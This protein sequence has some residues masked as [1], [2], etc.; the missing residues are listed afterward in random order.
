LSGLSPEFEIDW[1][2]D[3]VD[4]VREPRYIGRMMRDTVLAVL[5]ANKAAL[6]ARGVQRAA[7]FGSTARDEANPGSDVDIMVEIDPHA[8]VDLY[9]YVA[10]TH[11]IASLFP[12]AV[13][14]A[15]REQLLE[16]VR[17]TAEQDAV[18]AF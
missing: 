1:F 9:A 3:Q 18:Y 16:P 8:A 7:L 5:R 13:D 11:Y 10:I 14:V 6:Q 15:E 4:H 12:V 17:K 2:G